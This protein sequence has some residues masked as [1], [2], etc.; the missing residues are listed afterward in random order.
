MKVVTEPKRTYR[1]AAVL[2]FWR[3]C[4]HC[5]TFAPIFQQVLDALQR[6]NKLAHVTVHTVEVIDH[7]NK[8]MQYNVDLEDGVP[9]LI[10]YDSD[11]QPLV[12][13]GLREFA[14]VK[15]AME[16]YLGE[17]DEKSVT[18]GGSKHADDALTSI[19]VNPTSIQPDTLV[20]Y[21][22]PLCGFCRAFGPTYLQFKAQAAQ[23][24]PGLQVV[25][26]NVKV[27]NRALKDLPADVASNTVP[28]VVYH[29]TK[30]I[31][32]PFQQRRTVEK[33]LQFIQQHRQLTG[34]VTRHAH[35]SASATTASLQDMIAAV[36]H[37]MRID[38]RKYR[39]LFVGWRRQSDSR[40]DQ[41]YILLLSMEDPAVYTISGKRTGP[42][43][44]SILD[45]PDPAFEVTRRLRANY[46]PAST[47][48]SAYVALKDRGFEFFDAA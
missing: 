15:R 45:K 42:L 27:Y 41:L 16:G 23:S 18:G 43:S 47:I 25:A 14:D 26:V 33:L 40:N 5:R 19:S 1:N 37:K 4:G 11:G 8:L 21:Y 30:S 22:S 3:Q 29:K 36:V 13:E 2:Y 35:V 44:G 38:V 20:L 31:L 7:K 9:R 17:G 46:E 12:Y 32:I 6:E 28:H 48:D 10:L 34:G 24:T 39:V